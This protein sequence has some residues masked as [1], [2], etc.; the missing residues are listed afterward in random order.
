MR[1]NQIVKYSLFV[2]CY[3]F[4]VASGLM[5]TVGIY[6]KLCKETSPVDSLTT[7]PAIMLI[8]VGILMFTITFIGCMGAL[9]DLHLLLKIFAWMLGIVLIL[10]FVA[11]VLGFLFSGMVL[12]KATTVMSRA[13][14]QYRED[15]DLQNFIDYIQ[16]KFECC[17]V[18]SYQD[19]SKNIYF[20][21]T[22]TN[23]S[24][25][26]CAVPYSCCIREKGL[27]IINTMC[28]YETQNL[29]TWDAEEYINTEGCLEKIVNWGRGNLLL[30][31]GLAMG[32][33]LLEILVTCLAVIMIYQI[34]FIMQRRKS[35]APVMSEPKDRRIEYVIA[36]ECEYVVNY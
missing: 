18:N 13:I 6:A 27:K 33:I 30:L 19:W 8:V 1:T 12:Q 29:K 28:G 10:Q 25:E 2:S 32:L 7:D 36:E 9:R 23:P 4:W 20:L 31:G 17:G 5:I 3:I 21:C 16:K 34:S 11:A 15:L 22:A 24:L 26:K 35:T 14:A